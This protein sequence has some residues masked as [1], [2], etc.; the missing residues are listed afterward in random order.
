MTVSEFIKTCIS[1][2]YASK[3]DEKRILKWCEQNSK[4][5]GTEFDA[6][7]VPE[8]V[9]SIRHTMSVEAE[10]NF[11]CDIDAKT[12]KKLTGIDLAHGSDITG[13]TVLFNQ[14]VQ[15]RRHK[16]KRINKKWAKRYGYKTAFKSV[17]LE[18][19]YVEPNENGFDI[20]GRNFIS[21]F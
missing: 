19:A 3:K 11:E 4:D 17:K 20:L 10:A 13:C 8:Y 14:P 21:K 12:L 1:S 15:V 2:G 9:K 18:E 16:K 5:C 6:N 7:D